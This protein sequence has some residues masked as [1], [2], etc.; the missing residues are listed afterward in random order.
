[1]TETRDMPSLNS[2][3]TRT[4]DSLKVLSRIHSSLH[5][6]PL[7]LSY[8]P[9]FSTAKML[10][11]NKIN[12]AR[13]ALLAL[14]SVSVHALPETAVDDNLTVARIPGESSKINGLINPRQDSC[15][16]GTGYCSST[17]VCCP[18][19]GQCCNGTYLTIAPAIYYESCMLI[20]CQLMYRGRLL[21]GGVLLC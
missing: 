14:V 12:I 17:G 11:F 3:Y 4:F 2:I 19:G 6:S 15:P 13:M 16:G 1:M 9:P 7:Q 5:N 10:S 21:R 8:H 18:I 20:T